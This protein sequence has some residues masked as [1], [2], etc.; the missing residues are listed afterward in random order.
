MKNEKDFYEILRTK[1]SDNEH[2]F[3]EG[4]WKSMRTMI[5]KSRADKKRAIWLLTSLVF[6]LAA[7]GVFGLLEMNTKGLKSTDTTTLS[8]ANNSQKSSNTNAK[9][10]TTISSANTENTN[11][12]TASNN[13]ADV[14]N[15]TTPVTTDAKATSANVNSSAM[16]AANNSQNLKKNKS[17]K[18]RAKSGSDQTSANSLAAS[19]NDELNQIEHD[20]KVENVISSEDSPLNISSNQKPASNPA[21]LP[22][23]KAPVPAPKM[24]AKA[25]D[26]SKGGNIAIPSRFSDEPRVF[27]GMRNIFS[28][29]IG[30]EYSGGW[31]SGTL[32]Q[33]KGFNFVL[34][35][36]YSHYIGKQWFIKTGLQGSTF[37]N[38]STF[39]Y[40][41]Q[42]VSYQGGHYI[43]N[44]SVIITKRLYFLRVPLQFEKYIGHKSSIGFGGAVWYLLGSSG[45][46]TTYQQIDNNPPYNAKTYSQNIELPGY[47]KLNFSA[48]ALYRYT[49]SHKL[50]ISGMFY[51]ELTNMENNT[52]FGFNDI[53]KTKGIQI[54][55][56]Y[57]F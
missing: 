26:T 39:T 35:L 48:H 34:G 32:V 49:F 18:H 25:P 52:F 54:L 20:T 21:T 2:P 15:N 1:F 4:N 46:A 10:N 51:W 29:D 57:N 11:V 5:D 6:L 33:G 56:S 7:G 43:A 3:D 22:A 45:S 16:V 27:A 31:Q 47:T 24:V 40:N 12:S 41:Y 8:A 17:G 37:G 9:S 38:M 28:F 50:S 42:Q 13:H 14:V 19:I 53:E 30:T 23:A 44:D 55:A 36:G